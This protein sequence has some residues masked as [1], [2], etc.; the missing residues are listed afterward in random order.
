MVS[1][2]LLTTIST[3]TP[4]THSPVFLGTFLPSENCHLC[5][6]TWLCQ[7]TKHS[8][9]WEENSLPRK[10][11]P[12]LHPLWGKQTHKWAPG[13]S[14]GHWLS[15][16]LAHVLC[17]PEIRR[18]NWKVSA[19]LKE[20]VSQRKIEKY[21][22]RKKRNKEKGFWITLTVKLNHR[23]TTSLSIVRAAQS[24]CCAESS[25]WN[26]FPSFAWA[27]CII[28]KVYITWE[29]RGVGENT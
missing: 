29:M 15:G 13:I 10:L 2:L 12:C 14:S 1:P 26:T 5:V 20:S 3:T 18:T 24:L 7:M 16:G 9:E 22:K 4:S 8:A 11:L 27:L 25:P 6:Y 19:S 28:P 21:K 23:V 17:S